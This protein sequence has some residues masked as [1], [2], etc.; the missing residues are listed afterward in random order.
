LLKVAGKVNLYC[1][2]EFFETS[3]HAG[4]IPIVVVLCPSSD[5]SEFIFFK[6]FSGF[7]LLSSRLYILILSTVNVSIA[8]FLLQPGD[9]V[10]SQTFI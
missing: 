8:L 2:Y 10:C 7:R 6:G 4:K 3:K 5:R 1:P 9:L